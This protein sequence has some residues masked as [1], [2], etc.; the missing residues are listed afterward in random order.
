MEAPEHRLPSGTAGLVAPPVGS[1][2]DKVDVKRLAQTLWRQKWLILGIMA[3]LW[4]PAVLLINAM[5]PVYSASSVLVIDPQPNR[6]IN[7]PSVAEPMGIYLDT[8]N[9]EVETLRSRDL[10]RRVVETLSLG[11][12]P[13]YAAADGKPGLSTALLDGGR[14]LLTDVAEMLPEPLAGLLTPPPRPAAGAANGAEAEIAR[15]TDA[16]QKNLHIS[17]GVQSRAIRISVD[18]KDP[19][20][21]A[22][23]ANAVASTYIAMQVEA[24]R[25]ATLK[26][27]EWLQSRIDD[28]REDMT[29]TGQATIDAM[30]PGSGMM[31]GRDAPLV[32]EAMSALNAQLTEARSA[33]AN[34]LA[35]LR[36]LQ[37]V[38]PA[39]PESMAGADIGGDP[40]IAALRQRQAGL[41]AQLAELRAQY[42]ERHPALVR[43]TAEL[44]DLNATLATE[45]DRVVRGLRD[46][47]E[48]QFAKVQDLTRRLEELRN[49]AY[50]TLQ[51]DVKLR[52]LQRQADASDDNYRRA[53]TRLKET[54]VLQALQMMP[55]VRIVSAAAVPNGPVGPGKTVLAALAALVCGAVATGLALV[56]TMSQRGVYSS[57]Q[58]EA[59]LGQPA[60]GVVPLLGRRR[61]SD[62]DGREEKA[63]GD[64]AEAVWRLCARLHLVRTGAAAATAKGGEVIM[65]TSSVA[66]EGKTTLAVAMA[67]FLADAGRRVVV[68]DCDTRRPTVHR[69]LGDG[70]PPKGLIDLLGGDATLDQVLAIDERRRVA[71]IA[72]GR[73]NDRPQT[74]LGS[75]AML[76]LLVELSERYDV[77]VLDTPPVLSVSDALILAPLADRV[78][79]VVRWARTASSLANAGIKQ[80]RQVGGRIG[81]AVLSMVNAREHANL[82]YGTRPPSGRSY[83]LRRIA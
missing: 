79:Y 4:L 20:L 53:V 6:V 81:G 1:G 63:G 8:V 42:G 11:Q 19:Q 46:E 65:L 73:P 51:A 7:I 12:E 49:E 3:L 24:K 56:R 22:R 72:A 67:A 43:P 68:V 17:P 39:N 45:V 82:E 75:Q 35:R 15:L 50:S 18:A 38:K 30:R 80:V 34:A 64:F 28:L 27:S 60:V 54:Q 74:L 61:K 78:I 69:L 25:N 23:A 48:Q 10:A 31:K 9:T 57:H 29:A 21:A 41:S 76:S 44:R 26:A 58:V 59:L 47:V 83:R 13:E 55:D 77:V 5:T 66:G 14:A 33:H 2:A 32:N 37:T 16:F 62:P 52:E 36:Q 71:V 70:R 40:L